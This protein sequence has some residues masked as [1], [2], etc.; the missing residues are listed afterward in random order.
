MVKVLDFMGLRYQDLY[1]KTRQAQIKRDT[2]YKENTN[3]LA[4]YIIKTILINQYADFISWC[5]TNH[6]SLLD[7]KKTMS[8]QREFCKY[9]EDHYKATSMLKNVHYFEDVLLQMN[10]KNRFLKNNIRMTMIE[11]A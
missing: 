5:D 9:I 3:V 6:F 10:V 8:H 7:F 4:Y 2:F 1:S 11:M